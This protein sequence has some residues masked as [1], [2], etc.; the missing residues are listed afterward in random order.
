MDSCFEGPDEAGTLLLKG[1]LTIRNVSEL[2]DA[3]LES[4]STVQGL[5]IRLDGVEET[6]LSCLQL[7]C[8]A[9]RTAVASG[10]SMAIEGRWAKPF[11]RAVEAAGYARGG[12]CR[13]ANAAFCFW[14]SGGRT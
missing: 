9:H 2:R 12:M 10:K 13:S 1:D 4:L 14:R 5:R 8:S 3:L 6:D 7:L 11:R